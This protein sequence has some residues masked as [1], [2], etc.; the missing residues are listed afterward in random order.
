[1]I[2]NEIIYG[3]HTIESF[4]KHNYKDILCVYFLKDSTNPRLK[5]IVHNLL[6]MNI[7]IHFVSLSTLNTLV[8]IRDAK[9][10]GVVASIKRTVQFK[11]SD[12]LELLQRNEALSPMLF[13]ILDGITDSRNFGACLRCADAAGVNAVIIPK[14]RSANLNAIAQKVA[15][16]AAESVKIIRVTN[17]IRIIKKLKEKN[18]WI[19]GTDS[20][21][22]INL[23]Q[24]ELRGSLALV[25][26]GEEKGIRK[27]TKVWCDQIVQI[28]MM[29]SVN[30]LNVATAT[31]VCLFEVIR[32]RHFNTI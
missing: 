24:M 31:G 2:Q 12:L 4:F 26:G 11:E 32:Q 10:Q 5:N 1:M 13:L 20:E 16:G 23:Y 28:P 7:K 3:I 17:I 19:I 9:H 15:S 8:N 30:T 21:A 29:G 14:N 25:L 6:K 22:N 27:L 18:I